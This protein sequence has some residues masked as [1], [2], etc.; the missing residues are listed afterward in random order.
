MK[1]THLAD[2]EDVLVFWLGAPDAPPLAQSSQWYKKDEAF[3]A[4]MRTNFGPTLD[5]AARGELES[6]QTTPRGRLAKIILF[7]Q[8]SRNIFRNTPR[9]FAQDGLAV[10][11]TLEAFDNGHYEALAP[12]ERG[13]ALMPLMHAEK[14]EHQNR[15]IAEFKKLAAEA[16]QDLV[17]YFTNSVDYAVRHAAIIERFGRFPHRNATLGRASTPEEVEF[18]KQPG[19]SF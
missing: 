14:L 5:A 19:S 7:D 11:L 3:D 8:F 4:K 2:P 10:A 15:C 18:L 16:P 1:Q 9:A 12:V 13:F 6:W 17:G